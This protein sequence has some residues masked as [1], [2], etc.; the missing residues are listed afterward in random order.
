MR[1]L[2][3]RPTQHV[4]TTSRILAAQGQAPHSVQSYVSAQISDV[5]RTAAA[6]ASQ[7]V[8]HRRLLDL[9]RIVRSRRGWS[10]LAAANP[11]HHQTDAAQDD[12][13]RKAPELVGIVVSVTH[14]RHAVMGAWAGAVNRVE[15]I[16]AAFNNKQHAI[17]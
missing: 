14:V 6:A 5:T 9:R 16:I 13:P 15:E 1:R 3:T 10:P 17:A 7:P 8:A 12:P 2:N 4:V 11:G